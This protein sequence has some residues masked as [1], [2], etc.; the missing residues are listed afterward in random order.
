MTT[1]SIEVNPVSSVNSIAARREARRR[2][3][4][5]NAESRLKKLTGVEQKSRK[6]PIK[7]RN[8]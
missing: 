6:Y 8:P 2:K 4:L 7:L 5:E 1:D 3:I